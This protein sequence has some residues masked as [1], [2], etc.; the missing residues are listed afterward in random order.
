MVETGVLI[1]IVIFLLGV[2]YQLGRHSNRIDSLESWRDE[3]RVWHKE[4]IAALEAIRLELA[5]HVVLVTRH[6]EEES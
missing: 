2:A 1:T 5:R 4:N 6:L 3:T